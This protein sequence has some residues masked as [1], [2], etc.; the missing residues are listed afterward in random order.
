MDW[1]PEKCKQACEAAA[2]DLANAAK[3]PVKSKGLQIKM[4]IIIGRK[5]VDA[6]PTDLA[7][8]LRRSHSPA[9]DLNGNSSDPT[10]HADE[11][12]TAGTN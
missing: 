2:R 12:M 9:T 8:L 6:P 1:D 11:Q 4:R 5:P 7:E 10:L 3:D